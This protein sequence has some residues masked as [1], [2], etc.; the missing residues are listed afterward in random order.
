MFNRTG[1]TPME[2]AAEANIYEALTWYAQQQ[3]MSVD[4]SQ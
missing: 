4:L 1:K 3:H 2:S